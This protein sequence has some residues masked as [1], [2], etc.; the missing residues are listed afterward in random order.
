LREYVIQRPRF[1]LIAIAF[2]ISACSAQNKPEVDA[3]D[4]PPP[5]ADKFVYVSA[6]DVPS[7]CY[8]DLG[9]LNFDEPYSDAAIDGE[10]IQMAAKLRQLAMV[11]YPDSADAVINVRTTEN[12]VGTIVTVSGEAVQLHEGQHTVECAM[13]KAPGVINKGLAIAAGGMLGAAAGAMIPGAGT[14]GMMAG[15][16][17][18]V[19]AVGTYLGVEQHRE[20]KKEEGKLRRQLAVQHAE[21]AHL[22]VK[23][24]SLQ[25]C[26]D[27]E[28]PLGDCDVKDALPAADWNAPHGDSPSYEKEQS[29]FEVEKQ[30]E[31]QQEYIHK[32]DDQIYELKRQL[33][34]FPPKPSN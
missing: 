23:R 29:Q 12:D 1:C 8:H 21:I 10:G 17:I 32:L 16:A 11:K 18:G 9:P 14:A 7:V 5:P 26:A 3:K 13:R 6:G 2:L 27:E 25:K 19:G 4:A 15:G 31:E 20:T 28:T 22:L 33:A 34:S 24:S 30:I